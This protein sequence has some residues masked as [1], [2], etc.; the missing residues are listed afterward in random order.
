MNGTQNE[1]R[2]HI[3]NELP[4]IRPTKPP[5]SPNAS[6]ITTYAIPYMGG[7]PCY[8]TLVFSSQSPRGMTA[9][10][11]ATQ[12]SATTKPITTLSTSAATTTSTMPAT[13]FLRT[14]GRLRVRSRSD[15]MC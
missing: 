4:F 14:G 10:T 7:R 13:A 15:D 2:N 6:A 8:Q 9:T 5:A 12:K 3:T 1:T 11:T